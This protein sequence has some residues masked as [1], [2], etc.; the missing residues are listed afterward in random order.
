MRP[1]TWVL[2]LVAFGVVILAVVNTAGKPLSGPTAYTAGPQTSGAWGA[3]T[4]AIT[5]FGSKITAP[6]SQPPDAASIAAWNNTSRSDFDV[7]AAQDKAAGVEGP[8]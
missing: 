3:L 4:A 7:L 1:I 6:S 5:T 8:F 2:L